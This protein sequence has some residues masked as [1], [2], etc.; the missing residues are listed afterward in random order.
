METI[1]E[2][3]EHQ[4]L[5]AETSHKSSRFWHLQNGT[6][7]QRVLRV[8]TNKSILHSG[9]ILC[10]VRLTLALPAE[11]LNL[12]LH[13]RR[14]HDLCH[15]YRGSHRL[16]HHRHLLR[17]R[18]PRRRNSTSILLPLLTCSHHRTSSR[19][20]TSRL[21]VHHRR[22]MLRSCLARRSP[23]AMPRTHDRMLPRRK[24]RRGRR[25]ARD[26]HR[27]CSGS[28]RTSRR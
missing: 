21:L 27:S 23:P 6:L 7:G 20:D 18:R 19:D 17:L 8:V 15:R 24:G 2:L 13:R 14:R 22:T 3:R 5:Q 9:T 25:V 10:H 26:R 11:H 1:W 28:R 4:L 16:H 12:L